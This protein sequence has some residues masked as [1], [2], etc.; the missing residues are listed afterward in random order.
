MLTAVVP[1]HQP[2]LEGVVL[3]EAAQGHLRRA[4]RRM[5]VAAVG[6]VGVLPGEVVPADRSPNQPVVGG[7]R[8][9]RVPDGC[10]VARRVAGQRDAGYGP[11][12]CC[13][14]A[15]VSVKTAKTMT[16]RMATGIRR[17]SGGVALLAFRASCGNLIVW[18]PF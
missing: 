8:S 14:W 17:V 10:E 4:A 7:S 12:C 2:H 18:V 9:G 6:L 11:R 5:G 3:G 15:S 13:A 16:A 1:G